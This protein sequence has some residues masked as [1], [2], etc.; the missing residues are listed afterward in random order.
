MAW[1]ELTALYVACC[2]PDGQYTRR[3]YEAN[4]QTAKR[5]CD[6]MHV[7]EDEGRIADGWKQTGLGSWSKG[8]AEEIQFGNVAIKL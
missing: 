8:K 3:S 5:L 6:R 2:E 1:D 4:K 7:L